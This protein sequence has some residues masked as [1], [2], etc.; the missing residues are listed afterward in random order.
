MQEETE[1]LVIRRKQID[2]E[3]F[4]AKE[5]VAG[6]ILDLQ[7]LPAVMEVHRAGLALE[8]LARKNPR[9]RP[10]G[11]ETSFYYGSAPWDFDRCVAAAVV[12]FE[13]NRADFPAGPSAPVVEEKSENTVEVKEEGETE[14]PAAPAAEKPAA[15]EE[16]EAAEPEG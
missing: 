6:L 12:W 3:S 2:P 10:F 4:D 9:E 1:K 8:A 16:K 5:E 14:P 7:Q 11:D 13:R 15:S